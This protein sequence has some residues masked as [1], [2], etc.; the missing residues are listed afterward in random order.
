MRRKDGGS[1]D[2]AWALR[3]VKR[4]LQQTGK[5]AAS[6]TQS[7]YI[8]LQ[9]ERSE[10]YFLAL[11][12]LAAGAHSARN[13]RGNLRRR[14]LRH[15]SGLIWRKHCNR[16]IAL[17]QI[18]SIP[19]LGAQFNSDHFRRCKCDQTIPLPLSLL[20]LFMLTM[21]IHHRALLS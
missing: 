4:M 16:R 10:D 15:I 13:R 17:K 21:V 19:E 9:R 2:A 5:V 1:V 7:T 6:A 3:L 11:V 14:D 12:Y 20:A 8:F 18:R